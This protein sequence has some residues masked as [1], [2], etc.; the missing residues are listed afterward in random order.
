MLILVFKAIKIYS[1][2]TVVKEI[3]DSSIGY[4]SYTT[5]FFSLPLGSNLPW[6][7]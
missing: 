5:F 6:K 1:D 3:T 7:N 4:Q 2:L